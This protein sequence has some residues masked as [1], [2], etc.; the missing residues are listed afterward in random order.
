MIVQKDDHKYSVDIGRPSFFT[1]EN[2]NEYKKVFE[3]IE[4]SSIPIVVNGAYYGVR[5]R[6]YNGDG[7][8]GGGFAFC[9]F[10]ASKDDRKEFARLMKE[11]KTDS[12]GWN[13]E[14][15]DWRNVMF[16]QDRDKIMHLKFDEKYLPCVKQFA[17][18]HLLTIS[19]FMMPESPKT[20]E[21]IVAIGLD[22]PLNSPMRV[23][24]GIYL[25]TGDLKDLYSLKAYLSEQFL[26]I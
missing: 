11:I 16:H 2:R 7:Y 5:E 8:G 18:E 10:F 14:I 19:P 17:D 24:F 25:A 9:F 13:F 26:Q 20:I 4:K 6:L 15:L 23:I 12:P 21:D 3:L 22:K 1:D